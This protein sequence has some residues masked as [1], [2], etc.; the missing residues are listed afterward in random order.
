MLKPYKQLTDIVKKILKISIESKL[1][2]E[3]ETYIES[4]RKQL[5]NAMYAWGS[6]EPFSN[7]CKLTSMYEGSIIRVIKNIDELLKQL[8]N[9]VHVIGDVELEN[10]FKEGIYLFIFF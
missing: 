9:A 10:K 3:E 1:E 2:L 5:V 4:F 7:I 6:G 8:V